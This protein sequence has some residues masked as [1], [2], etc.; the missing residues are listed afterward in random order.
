MLQF[1]LV[2]IFTVFIMIDELNAPKEKKC[3]NV[4][5]AFALTVCLSDM[6]LTMDRILFITLQVLLSICQSLYMSYFQLVAGCVGFK[7]YF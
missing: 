5:L 7:E 6:W 2:E 1:S 3:V 4:H